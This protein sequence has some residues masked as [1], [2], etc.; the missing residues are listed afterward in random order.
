MFFKKFTEK[1]KESDGF[2][3]KR[4]KGDAGGKNLGIG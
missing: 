2:I 3:I 1:K 4:E